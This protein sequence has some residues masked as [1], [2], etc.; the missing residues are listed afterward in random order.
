MGNERIDVTED[1]EYDSENEQYNQDYRHWRRHTREPFVF[2][3]SDNSREHIYVEGAPPVSMDAALAERQALMHCSTMLGAALLI[4]LLSEV[5]GSSLLIAAM[6]MLHIPISINFLDFKMG[7]SQW[8]VTGVRILCL[9]LKY[10]LPTLILTKMCKIPQPVFAPASLGAIPEMIAAVGAGMMIA[11][12][13]S[14]AAIGT[15]VQTSQRLFAYKDIA[16]IGTYGVFDTLAVSVLAELFF[17]GAL[18]PLLRQFGDP[19]SVI[20]TALIG[21]LCP[22][23]LP[24]RICEL[25]IGLAAGY[26]LIRSGSIIKCAALR[27][28]YSA[29]KYARLG[30]V[31]ASEEIRLWQYIIILLGIGT[32]LILFFVHFRRT[33]LMLQNRKTFLPMKKKLYYLTQSVPMLPWLAASLLLML[34]NLLQ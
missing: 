27:I 14:T 11:A 21:F 9:V 12:V 10:G 4:F 7:G 5:L 29:L 32:V 2:H 22:N 15:S 26:L 1:F 6:K 30:L 25:L 8:A 20:V 19:F 13:Y 23:E 31:Y 17:R 18:L 33:K 34:L 16:A 3:F 24:E 28:V